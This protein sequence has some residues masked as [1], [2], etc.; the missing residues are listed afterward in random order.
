MMLLSSETLQRA[1]DIDEAT[2]SLWLPF[3]QGTCKAF[4]ITSPKRVAAFLAQI[5]HESGEFR[6]VDENL[7]YSAKG[8][9]Q[10]FPRYFPNEE[11]ALKYQRKPHSIANKVY[12]NRMGNGDEAS[13]DGW[14]YRGKGLIQLTGKDNHKACGDAIGE[15]FVAFPDRLLMP[16]NAALSAGWFWKVKSLNSLADE[17]DITTISKRIN[18]GVIGLEERK[19]KYNAAYA[20][21]SKEQ[22]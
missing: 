4:E 14:K 12:A 11:I 19:S 21:L 9:M 5:A 17:G 6:N 15:D 2:A 10:T 18:G 3:L 1:I 20:I 8:L 7:N 16:V 13:G 22:I